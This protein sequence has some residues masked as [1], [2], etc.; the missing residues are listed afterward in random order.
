M[1]N[2]EIL[3]RFQ[4]KTLRAIVNAPWIVPNKLIRKDLK[5][6]TVKE[7]IKKSVENYKIRFK[8]HPNKLAS[9]LL[10]KVSMKSRFKKNKDLLQLFISLN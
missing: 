10:K 7:E 3:E 5:I 9:N 6:L 8:T 4:S 2:I 1:S